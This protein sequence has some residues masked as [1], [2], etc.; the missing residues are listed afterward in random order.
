MLEPREIAAEH[1]AERANNPGPTHRAER[2]VEHETAVRHPRRSR[3]DGGPG[4]QQRDEAADEN[5]RGA[6]PCK[7]MTRA[8]EVVFLWVQKAPIAPHHRD[9]ACSPN[10]VAAVVADHGRSDGGRH[11][12]VDREMS[13]RGE[14]GRRD[15]SGLARE[16]ESEALEADQEEEYDVAVGSNQPGYSSLHGA[17]LVICEFFAQRGCDPG[18]ECF[19]GVHELRMR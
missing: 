4:A 10:P 1:V 2:I 5:G 7:E 18:A 14:G 16:G 17:T 3:E 6:V 9:A 15:Q 19:D 13:Q 8:L 11:D 12:S